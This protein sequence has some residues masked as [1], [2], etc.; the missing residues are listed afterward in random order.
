MSSRTARATRRNPVSKNQKQ[1]A[2][3]T[4]TK[5]EYKKNSHI[6]QSERTPVSPTVGEGGR[7]HKITANSRPTQSIQRVP[8]Q[9]GATCHDLVSKGGKKIPDQ[10]GIPLNYFFL[11][12]PGGKE[13]MDILPQ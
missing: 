11:F 5:P 8:G 1:T 9:T 6:S 12:P 2:T 3:T 7:D 13:W 10:P 4:T